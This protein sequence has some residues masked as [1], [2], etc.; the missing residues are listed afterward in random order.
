MNKMRVGDGENQV[1]AKQ[2]H[3]QKNTR[4]TFKSR[5]GGKQSRE[6]EENVTKILKK[7]NENAK[8]CDHNAKQNLGRACKGSHDLKDQT[9]RAKRG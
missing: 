3:A 1:M 8:N 9:K 2:K 6:L 5:P 4:N 7:T